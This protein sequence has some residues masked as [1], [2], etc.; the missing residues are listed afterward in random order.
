M[1]GERN[2]NR[3]FRRG[4][5][6]L[7]ENPENDRLEIDEENLSSSILSNDLAT[8]EPLGDIDMGDQEDSPN[9]PIP[10]EIPPPPNLAQLPPRILHS[11]TVET[12][13]GQNEDL[14]ARLKVNLRRNASL[15]QQ[16]L[17]LERSLQQA[18]QEN[19]SLQ[20]QVFIV[21][22]KDRIYKAKNFELESRFD[23]QAAEIEL[24]RT[25]LEEITFT[26][27]AKI[28]V[29]ESYMR[30][31][32]R[33]ARPSMDKFRGRLDRERLRT[34]ELVHHIEQLRKEVAE[35]DVQITEVKNQ[36][37]ELTKFERE[38]EQRFQ[39]DQ[40]QLVD[41]YESE[42]QE[43]TRLI[44]KLEHDVQYFKERSSRLD[45]ATRHQIEAE[46]RAILYERKNVELERKLNTEVHSLQEAAATYRGEANA[47]AAE[48]ESI[49]SETARLREERE[50]SESENARLNEQMESLQALWGESRKENEA[51][52]LRLA[53]LNKINH[54]LSRK[55]KDQRIQAETK[56]LELG[57]TEPV[58]A[59]QA[60]TA[61]D[62]LRDL[63][64]ALATIESGFPKARTRDSEKVHGLE[65]V[66]SQENTKS[67]IQTLP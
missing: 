34:I 31:V 64:S 35:R 11:G 10:I 40:A 21:Q 39:Q 41:R 8:A 57:R 5:A 26:T 30:R 22:E 24:L 6:P 65:I 2:W 59:A 12:L 54:E 36:L 38:R 67:E 29:L 55:L 27:Q 17:E 43:R 60:N 51:L 52:E 44:E 33:W 1:L 46:N 16:I 53:A 13:I 66:E 45:T 61:S 56:A 37:E 50:R 18:R 3:R 32:R 23:D 28:K 4:T 42:A 58:S 47:L 14:M 63:D 49:R 20:D 15:E 9:V 7:H 25:K 62:R 48:L 19:A